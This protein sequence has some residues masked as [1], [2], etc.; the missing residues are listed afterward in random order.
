MKITFTEVFNSEVGSIIL[1]DEIINALHKSENI[2][3]S[4]MD[5]KTLFICTQA[6]T[7]KKY[8]LIIFGFIENDDYKVHL[9]F[10][11]F[12]DSFEQYESE[13]PLKILQ[14][15]VKKYGLTIK[16]GHINET[17]IHHQTFWVRST[18]PYSIVNI[19]NPNNNSSIQNIIVKIKPH[20][21]KHR[22]DCHLGFCINKDKYLSDIQGRHHGN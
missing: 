14:E 7:D 3:R 21:S 15:F 17:F 19:Q 8:L 4:Q 22:V 12:V 6:C 13:S 2:Y 1:K 20:G 11:Y 16:I 18:N 5:S 10:K 9:A